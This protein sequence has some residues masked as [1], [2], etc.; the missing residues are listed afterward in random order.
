[1]LTY[2][3]NKIYIYNFFGGGGLF[4]YRVSGLGIA[5]LPS[6]PTFHTH[7]IISETCDPAQ[8]YHRSVS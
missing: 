4:Y 7:N 2:I 1:M 8:R 3:S 6:V 5:V